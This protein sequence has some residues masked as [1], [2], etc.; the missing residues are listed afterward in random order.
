MHNDLIKK[1]SAIIFDF[2][3]TLVD[4][5]PIIR[6]A[7]SA[8]FNQF[9]IPKEVITAENIDFNRSLR[10][11]F[12]KIFSNNLKEAAEAYY[13][14][15]TQFSEELAILEDA[16]KVLDLL[17]K[18]KVFMS[19]VSNKKGHILREEVVNK[20]S[21]QHYFKSIIGSGDAEEDKPSIKPAIK[22]LE[23]ANLSNYNDVW[24]IGDSLVDV[25]TANNLGCKAIFFN[26][27]PLSTTDLTAHLSVS[28]HKKLLELLSKIYV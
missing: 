6:K 28:N 21:W 9:N 19:I 10:D 11:Y 18:N 22:S 5:R 15:Y 2:D 7:L 4:S 3:D 17:H 16:E 14:Y 13:S 27:T 25:Q 8:T 23:Y 1:P 12:H 26:P 20:F 24:L